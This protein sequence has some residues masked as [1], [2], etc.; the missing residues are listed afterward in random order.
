LHTH[1]NIVTYMLHAEAVKTQLHV[2]A[3]NLDNYI[4]TC[5]VLLINDDDVTVLLE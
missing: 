5:N 2:D 1:A 3:L 4:T